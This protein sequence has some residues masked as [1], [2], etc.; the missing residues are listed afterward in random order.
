M[1]PL[2]RRDWQGM[3]RYPL[4]KMRVKPRGWPEGG[5]LTQLAHQSGGQRREFSQYDDYVAELP[6]A[7]ASM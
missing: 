4:S 7:N 2:L 5:F 6:L 1:G 3:P